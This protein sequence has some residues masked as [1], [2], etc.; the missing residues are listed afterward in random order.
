MSGDELDEI[1]ARIVAIEQAPEQTE[2][3]KLKR[4]RRA[5]VAGR[6]S[7]ES[8]RIGLEERDQEIRNAAAEKGHTRGCITDLASKFRLSRRQIRRIIGADNET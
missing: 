3:I 4:R 6:A 5:L 7:G 2:L 1:E 8:R